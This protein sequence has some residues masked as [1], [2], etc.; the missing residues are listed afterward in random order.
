MRPKPVRS[1]NGRAGF[2]LIEL[3]IVVGMISIVLAILVLGVNRATSAFSLRRAASI[4][5][6]ELR[7][8][9]ASA[10]ADGADYI[11][12][13]Y[14]STGSSTPGGL[15]VWKRS[16][17][18]TTFVRS[19]LAPDWPRVQMMDGPTNFP[20]CTG[21]G[22]DPTHDCAVFKSLGYLDSGSTQNRMRLRSI[23]AGTQLDIVVA[24]ATA[25]VSVQLP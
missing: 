3:V 2:T 8:A 9:Q 14:V 12:E 11:V 17:A 16:G 24:P 18:T 13:F 4:V 21:S 19:I 6:S 23:G 15:R 25:H 22:P 10:V 1:K 20:D 7:R 5:M